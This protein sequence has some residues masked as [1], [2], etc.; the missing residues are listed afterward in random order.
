MSLVIAE[1]LTKTYRAS[2]VEVHAIKGAD[3]VIE[4]A[5]FVAFVG[6]SGSGKSSLLNMIGC[7]D[8][9]T[10]GKLT[11]LGTDISTLDRRAAAD[12]RG[13]NIGFIFQD[14]NLVPVLTAYENIE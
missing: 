7:L 14:F 10:S 2:E 3:F 9:P 8:H 1:G 12:F 11:V 5:S 4:P 6:P 13:K